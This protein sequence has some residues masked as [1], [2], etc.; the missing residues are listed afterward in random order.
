MNRNVRHNPDIYRSD[1]SA[2][3]L[4][5]INQNLVISLSYINQNSPDSSECLISFHNVLDK[6]L[7]VNPEKNRSDKS[8]TDSSW[9]SKF[10]GGSSANQTLNNQES[11]DE[12]DLY[13]GY[14]QLFGYVVLNYQFDIDESSSLLESSKNPWWFNKD[15][16]NDYHDFANEL[17][18]ELK[19]SKLSN[20]PFIKDKLKSPSV[21]GGKLGGISDLVVENKVTDKTIEAEHRYLLNDLLYTF[22]SLEYNVDH[23]SNEKIPTK[24][25][26]DSI[27]PIYSTP[28]G[29]LFS[30]LKLEPLSTK[31]FHIKFPK[32]RNLPPSYNTRLTGPLCDQGLISIKYSLIV[33]VSLDRGLKPLSVYFPLYLKPERAGIDR[34]WLQRR[35]SDK[36][37]F[38]SNW[39][40][41]VLS[42][43]LDNTP[44]NESTTE[45]FE[46][47]KE[48]LE[49][50]SKLIISDLHNLPKISHETR[51]KSIG[52]IETDKDENLIPQLPTHLKTQ[53]QIRVNK[54]DLCLINLTKPYYHIGED[55]NFSI[56]IN[57]SDGS[58]TKVVGFIAYLEACEQFEQD[59][60]QESFMNYY[61]VTPSI[62]INCFAPA[63]LNSQT[64]KSLSD[65]V[66]GYLNIPKFLTSQ[67][68]YSNFLSL[69]Y[70]LVFKFNLIDFN[71]EDLHHHK[72]KKINGNKYT[73]LDEG[74]SSIKTAS[75]H[76]LGAHLATLDSE[77]S[78]LNTQ[79]NQQ[80]SR[81]NSSQKD[82]ASEDSIEF[83][84][85]Y[86]HYNEGNEMR[87]R[88]P[89]VL[90]P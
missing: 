30:D 32:L 35:Y 6:K 52:Y 42:P 4:K 60:K 69:K 34:R 71:D 57:P 20:I 53:F 26:I 5:K 28:Q 68:Q 50:L 63:I 2:D 87:I 11:E 66:N 7:N 47:R 31:T 40:F 62:K 15:Y 45:N 58:T 46:S 65:Y 24:D 84:Q 48:L 38:D 83:G 21:I 3:L 17:S 9:Y 67:F 76:D 16:V 88:L 27:I 10:F 81:R 56:N 86:K 82:S 54:D 78:A 89:I 43:N 74:K 12:L 18:D 75:N 77:S 70:F 90:L 23:E 29:L 36:V 39:K 8:E 41:D 51:H 13:L 1:S 37:I 64:Q 55:I 72:E 59:N 79:A 61:K 80:T 33:G 25:L 73:Q 22:N 44:P 19:E 49:D 14:I 85:L